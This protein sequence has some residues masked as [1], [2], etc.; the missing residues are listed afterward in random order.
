VRE[1]VGAVSERRR[2]RGR[3]RERERERKKG[4]E[5]TRESALPPIGFFFPQ[6]FLTP[7][8]FVFI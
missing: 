5:R 3:E 1:V 4:K 6:S 7:F 8:L 2:E